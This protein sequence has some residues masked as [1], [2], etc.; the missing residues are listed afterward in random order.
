M[1]KAKDLRTQSEGE[2]E[3]QLDDLRKEIY[4]LRNALSSK[5]EDVKPF[6]IMLK[7]KDIARILTILRERQI[8]QTV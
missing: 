2:L 4:E 3:A 8:E 5:K 7:R 6:K 1:A